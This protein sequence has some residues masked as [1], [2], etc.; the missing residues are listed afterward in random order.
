MK[1]QTKPT[2]E[3]LQIANAARAVFAEVQSKLA[4][5]TK[6]RGELISARDALALDVLM[7]DEAAKQQHAALDEQVRAADAELQMLEVAHRQAKKRCADAEQVHLLAEERD[8]ADRCIVEVGG[9]AKNMAE[10]ERMIPVMHG[11]FATALEHAKK[12]RALWLG[13]LPGGDAL[14][15]NNA[16]LKRAI[17]YQFWKAT[18]PE[19]VGSGAQPDDVPSL[20]GCENPQALLVQYASYGRP[21]PGMSLQMAVPS[22]SWRCQ[23]A[24]ANARRTLR[25]DLFEEE[26]AASGAQLAESPAPAEDV[27]P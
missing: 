3:L 24:L 4:A 5:A 12:A 18:W 19:F 15:L 14:M 8:R 10:I 21:G 1:F 6:N 27:A 20:P 25:P 26:I 11:Y 16:T 22:L 9:L 17:A 13:P 2:T 23:D 7:G